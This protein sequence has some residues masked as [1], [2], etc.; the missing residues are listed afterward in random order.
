M[1]LTA[2]FKSPAFLAA[3]CLILFGGIP[4]VL[5][6][7]QLQDGFPFFPVLLGLLL[8]TLIFGALDPAVRFRPVKKEC[9]DAR[10]WVNIFLR[11][12]AAAAA[13]TLFTYWI[14]PRLFLGLPR[15]R[16]HIW[17]MV[18]VLYPL[19]SVAPQEFIF[20]TYFMQRYQP[21]FGS[22]TFMLVMNALAFGWA[23]IF[24]LNLLAPLL[25]VIGGYL[26]AKTWEKTR[27]FFMVSVEHAVYGQIVFTTGLGW[28]FY[29]GTAQALS[30]M[31]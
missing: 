19:L 14:Y 27:S 1:E 24:F 23:H 6:W 20:R 9:C 15:E 11:V 17:R 2:R 5:L 28:F 13:L 16:P 30:Q 25:C 31:N 8:L 4:L 7:M 12:A 21:L 26:I 22:G 10:A 29:N 18:M 3:E